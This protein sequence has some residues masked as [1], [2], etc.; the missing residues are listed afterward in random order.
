MTRQWEIPPTAGLPLRWRDLFGF[1]ADLADSLARQFSIPRPALPCSGTAALIIAL[2]TLQQR[3]PGRTR[4]IVPAYTCPLVALAA[5]YCPPLRVV[6]CDL[7]PNSI[8]LDERQLAQLCDDSTLAVVVTHL[9]GRVADV[10][11]AKRIA[12]TVGAAVI[13][14]AAQAMGALDDGHSVGLKGD[15]GFFSLALGKGLTT[16]EGGV[17]FSRD[18]VLHQALHR[19]CQ[20]DLP[21]S[22]RWELQRSA[23]LWGYA[24]AYQP[25]GLYYVYGKGL[26]A[27]LAQGDEVAAVGDDFSV[28][29]IP[30]HR[31]GGYRQ[32]VGAAALARLP[33]YLQQGRTRALRRAA[34]L[35][36]LPGV[37]VIMDRPGQQGTWPF[38]M[39]V[40]PSAHARDAAMAPLWT[41]GLGVTRLF[42]HTLPGYRNV[43]PLLQ[44]G[45]DITQAQEFATRTL[46]ISNSHWLTDERFEQVLAQLKVIVA[47]PD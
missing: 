11:T 46:S 14:D 33:D 36:A 28:S 41:S 27:A 13:E 3:M 39:V 42:I 18:P 23:E 19:Q 26:R 20:Q 6:P 25:R 1:S 31:L 5:H 34:R 21:L 16:A 45:G 9:A 29:D 38:L 43:I 17:L 37:S 47:N 44:P 22:L 35:N 12:G 7:Q 24:L 2:R 10:D 4:L 8:D 30:L 15:V 32:Q 40:M